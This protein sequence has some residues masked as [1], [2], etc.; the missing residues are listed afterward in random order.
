VRRRPYAVVLL[1]EVEKAHPDVFNVLLQVLDDGRLTDGQ[2]R[3]VDFTQH[4][5]IVLTSNLG[6]AVSG[7]LDGRAGRVELSSRQV[8]DVVRAHFRPEF[9]NR[10]DEIILFH[11]LGHQHMAPIVDLQVAR[12]QAL[13]KERK[14]SARPDRGGEALAGPV[15]YD[16]VYGARPLKRAVQRY[17]QDPLPSGCWGRDPRWQRGEDRRGRRGADVRDRVKRCRRRAAGGVA[18]SSA[19]HRPRPPPGAGAQVAQ[20]QGHSLP[21]ATARP[22]LSQRACS[23]VVRPWPRADAFVEHGSIRPAT[24]FARQA[25]L[26]DSAGCRP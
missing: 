16:P 22:E 18:W 7:D 24:G 23:L 26:P 21:A 17:V 2:G 9:L 25:R 3:T 15:G 13:L 4:R 19:P 10:L 14:I 20:P 5:C 8:M 11:R 6:S 12:V 1:D